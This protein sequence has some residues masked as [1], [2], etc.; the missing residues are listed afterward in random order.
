LKELPPDLLAATSQLK[1]SL[2]PNVVRL[3]H[4]LV[5]NEEDL[6]KIIKRFSDWTGPNVH[7]EANDLNGKYITRYNI[8][9]PIKEGRGWCGPRSSVFRALCAAY[10]IP[11]R[12]IGGYSL[13]SITAL[14]GG[15]INARSDRPIK[16]GD[17]NAHVWAEVFLPHVGWVEIAV[18]GGTPDC[19]TSSA[20]QVAVYGNEGPSID[21]R[22]EKGNWIPFND[23]QNITVTS[24]IIP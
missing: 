7:Q 16:K 1:T 9:T 11:A 20:N 21:V 6:L 5:G 15:E 8:Q 14:V 18:G 12:E 4:T 13:C 24:E 17:S 23:T 19:F 10:D 22:N 3:A 2:P